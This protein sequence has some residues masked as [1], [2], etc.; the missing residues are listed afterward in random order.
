MAR[1]RGRLAKVREHDAWSHDTSQT[2]LKLGSNRATK[3]D[4]LGTRHAQMS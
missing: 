2:R 1:R 4:H 3:D